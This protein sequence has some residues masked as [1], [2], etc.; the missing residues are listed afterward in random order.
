[1]FRQSV[2]TEGTSIGLLGGFLGVTFTVKLPEHTPI[3]RIDKMTDVI[4]GGAIGHLFIHFQS[5]LSIGS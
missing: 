3:Y 5:V 1:M 2:D 4:V